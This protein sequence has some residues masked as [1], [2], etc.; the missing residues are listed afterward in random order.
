MPETTIVI[1]DE[2]TPLRE[3]LFKQTISDHPELSIQNFEQ[4]CDKI[5]FNR[6]PRDWGTILQDAPLNLWYPSKGTTINSRNEHSSEPIK[7]TVAPRTKAG[8]EAKLKS[9]NSSSKNGTAVKALQCTLASW[10]PAWIR[11]KKSITTYKNKRYLQWKYEAPFIAV[12]SG[13]WPKYIC[14]SMA[15]WRLRTHLLLP[16]DRKLQ[17]FGERV[18]IVRVEVADYHEYS[19]AEDLEHA[20]FETIETFI[21]QYS[22]D[23]EIT[24]ESY[25]SDFYLPLQFQAEVFFPKGT[26]QL[27]QSFATWFRSRYE[28]DFFNN[29]LPDRKPVKCTVSN[30]PAPIEDEKLPSRPK[31]TANPQDETVLLLEFSLDSATRIGNGC[32][33]QTDYVNLARGFLDE[34]GMSPADALDSVDFDADDFAVW[35]VE[36]SWAK[37]IKSL[38]HD[39]SEFYHI[40]DALIASH[41][42][43]GI[44]AIP[45]VRLL[46]NLQTMRHTIWIGLEE[47]PMALF[48]NRH[49][50]ILCPTIS[51]NTTL[52]V[53]STLCKKNT[54]IVNWANQHQLKIIHP[55]SGFDGGLHYIRLWREVLVRI[56][57]ERPFDPF[58]GRYPT[59]PEFL[60]FVKFVSI[61]LNG[62]TIKDNEADHYRRYFL[63]ESL[64]ARVVV[65]T[66]SDR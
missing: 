47:E 61:Q 25:V 51:L 57:F 22:E 39:D 40:R 62:D 52:K 31:P 38:V 27:A 63:P 64:K 26:F 43:K 54:D 59:W 33:Y 28:D 42:P 34:N 15:A 66:N 13:A 19:A 53:A 6:I 3:K 36:D 55:S 16:N 44:G 21:L 65:T 2:I 30:S 17:T 60:N 24:I 1:L 12:R 18:P 32:L 41:I 23:L 11:P 4:V 45:L 35:I 50:D 46:L 37:Y 20:L 5:I 29:D 56:F 48:L 7:V 58:I 10:E 9:L 8:I 14:E 49:F